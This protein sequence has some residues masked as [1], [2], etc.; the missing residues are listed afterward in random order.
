MWHAKISQINLEHASISHAIGML[1][2]Y[3][4]I[5]LQNAQ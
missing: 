4:E 5:S 3:A 1:I 2:G